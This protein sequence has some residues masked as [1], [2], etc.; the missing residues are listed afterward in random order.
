MRT[1]LPPL[2]NSS[3]VAATFVLPV[4]F[5]SVLSLGPEPSCEVTPLLG[6]DTCGAF[7]LSVVPA[8]LWEAQGAQAVL[9]GLVCHCCTHCPHSKHPPSLQRGT[10][11]L[12]FAPCPG[13]QHLCPHSKVLYTVVHMYLIFV[14]I[15]G[16]TI[17]RFPAPDDQALACFPFTALSSAPFSRGAV[18]VRNLFP[19]EPSSEL[20]VRVLGCQAAVP[21]EPSWALITTSSNS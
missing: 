4:I 21:E 8:V 18:P 19:W 1:L 10:H 9:L 15:S 3:P 5:H 11:P 6:G 2:E 20:G 16:G 17:L 12:A 13:E 7:W 14:F